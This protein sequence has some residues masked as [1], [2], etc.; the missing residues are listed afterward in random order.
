MKVAIDDICA[1][2]SLEVQV[3]LRSDYEKGGWCSAADYEGNHIVVFLEK[4][5]PG[6]LR[7]SQAY[8]PE[9]SDEVEAE[10]GLDLSG[11]A[12]SDALADWSKNK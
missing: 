7:L 1:S 5:I 4:D 6:L 10:H 12:L 2:C 11:Q 9:C 8:C 3:V